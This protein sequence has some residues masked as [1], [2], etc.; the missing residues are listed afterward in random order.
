MDF[1]MIMKH[2][3]HLFITQSSQFAQ[4]NQICENIMKLTCCNQ[5]FAAGL[6]SIRI[7]V[8]PDFEVFPSREQNRDS[9]RR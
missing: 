5:M 8:R 3:V 4:R 6:A 1:L 9:R 2:F 7:L